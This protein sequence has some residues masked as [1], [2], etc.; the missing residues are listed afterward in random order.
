MIVYTIG[1]KLAASNNN[2]TKRHE[3]TIEKNLM[4]YQHDK[5][6]RN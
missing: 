3:N 2:K 4:G 1:C 5:A 6:E